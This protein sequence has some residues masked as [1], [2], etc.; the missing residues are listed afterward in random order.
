MKNLAGICF[1]I[2]L[3]WI[4]ATTSV[5]RAPSLQPCTQKWFSYLDS[6]YFDISDG[7]GHGPDIG[8][9]EWLGS[10]EEK[11]GLPVNENLPDEQRC[12]LIQNQLARHT[13]IVNQQLGWALSL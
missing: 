8:S 11:A 12:Q 9:S 6:H 13:Y 3:V 10:I 4:I 5:S 7:E 2:A 1:L